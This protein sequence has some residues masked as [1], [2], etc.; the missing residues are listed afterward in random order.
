VGGFAMYPTLESR[1]DLLRILDEITIVRGRIMQACSSLPA[2]RLHD[3]VIAGT[4]SVLQIMAHLGRVE[5]LMV[6]CMRCRPQPLPAE[7][8]PPEPSLNLPAVATVLDEAHAGAIAFLK[9][10]PESVLRESC[11]Y[12]RENKHETV[13]GLYFHLFEHEFHHRAFAFFKLGKLRKPSL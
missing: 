9:A 6:E 12:G 1:S 10:N 2:D 11:A 3:P 8:R 4:W 7:R 5:A 13:G